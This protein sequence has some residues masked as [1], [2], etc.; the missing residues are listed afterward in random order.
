MKAKIWAV[1]IFAAIL[2][3]ELLFR[4]SAHAGDVIIIA[5]K[6]APAS[7]MSKEDIRIVFLAKKDQWDN[8]QKI[9]FVILQDCPEHADFL[10][11]YL[12]KTSSQF[13]RYF[14]TLIF[15]GKGRAPRAFKTEKELVAYV[16]ATEGA[17]G[18]VSTGTD[19]S[20]VR[21]LTVN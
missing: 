13:Q 3:M 10:M 15:T 2:G 4:G 16:A 1:L 12:K 20:S 9:D 18:Y 21:V 11:K 8:G 5:N 6:N 7:S 17:I 19:I 14:K